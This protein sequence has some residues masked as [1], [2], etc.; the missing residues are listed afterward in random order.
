[1]NATSRRRGSGYGPPRP[2]AAL[3]LCGILMISFLPCRSAPAHAG[4]GAAA[5]AAADDPR[6]A[7]TELFARYDTLGACLCVFEK[8]R[9][10]HT[11]CYGALSPDGAAVTE[12]TLFRVGSISKMVAAMGVMRLVDE[13]RASLDGD[14]SDLI[15][16]TVRNPWYPSEPITLRQLMSH[17]AGFRDSGLYSLALRGDA[18]PLSKL[19]S[20]GY[21]RYLFYEDTSPGG[22]MTYSNFGGGLLGVVIE[23]LTGLTVDEYMMTAVFAPLGVTAAY[24]AALLPG[25]ASVADM[26]N[27]PAGTLNTAVRA[28][29]APSGAPDTLT[30]YT[31]TAGKLAISAPDLARLLIALCDGGAYGDT[32]VLSEAACAEMRTA[33]NGV[34]SVSCDGD[35]GLDMN[36]VADTLVGGRTL[37]GHGGKANGMLCAAYFDPT[38][39]TGVVMLTNGCNNRA[40]TDGIGTLSVTA[41]KLCYSAWIDGPDAERNAWL[42]TE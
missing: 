2:V 21:V 40:M 10:T 15:G 32:R 5:Q 25:T 3:L 20:L 13:G 39:R 7:L 14:L 23:N 19:F 18:A 34:G 9:V 31:L 38:D 41:I 28:D 24:N 36:I 26:Y 29:V 37:Y 33:Q 17:T 12:G 35:W 42:V 6:A 27:M 30:D 4:T 22:K 8:G 11:V 16:V 1:M